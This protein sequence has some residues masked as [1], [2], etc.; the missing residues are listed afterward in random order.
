M[1]LD[2]HPGNKAKPGFEAEYEALLK[3]L[4]DGEVEDGDPEHER[5]FEISTSAYETLEAPRA[6]HDNAATEWARKQY[7]EQKPPIPWEDWLE[8]MRGYYVLDLC[9][10][11]DGLPKYTNA[12]I[13]IGELYTFRAQFLRDCT[14]VIGDVMLER[15]YAP[16]SPGE[17]LSYGRELIAMAESYAERNGVDLANTVDAEEGSPADKVDI[18]T[19]AGRW[20]VFWGERSHPLDSDW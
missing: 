19:A 8:E 20:C 14:D 6:G 17:M 12:P 1:G 2:W 5:Y 4:M 3:K 7:N 15:G 10:P 11:C 13:G 9:S 16:M 18:V